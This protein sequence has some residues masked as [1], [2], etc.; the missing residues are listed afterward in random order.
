MNDIILA[1]FCCVW[2]YVIFVL[3]GE[4]SS[5]AATYREREIREGKSKGKRKKGERRYII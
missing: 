3:I 4:L 2:K 5:S 1:M